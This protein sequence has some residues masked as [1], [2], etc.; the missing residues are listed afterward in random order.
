MERE[1]AVFPPQEAER[2]AELY[3]Y[4]ILDTGPD[5]AL[6][7]LV[8]LAAAICQA[9]IAVISLVDAERQWFKSKV[10]LTETQ[11][12]RIIA[13]CAHTILGD[14]LLVVPDARADP[15]FVENPLVV[16]EPHIRFYCG[17]PLTTPDGHHIG[18]LGVIDRVPR[19]LVLEQREAMRVLSHQVMDHLNLECRHKELVAAVGERLKAEQALLASQTKFQRLSD[20]TSSGIYIY[21]GEQFLYANPAASAISGFS[22]E[23]LKSLSLWD[24]VHP[25]FHAPLKARARAVEAGDQAPAR[26]EFPIIAKDGQIRWLDF[27][28]ASIEYDGQPARI[29]TAIDITTQKQAE[30]ALHLSEERFALAVAGTDAGIWD[31]DVISNTVYY[32]PRWKSMLGYGEQDLPDV[33]TTWETLLHPDDRARALAAVNDYLEGKT[34]CYEL[35]HRLRHKDGSYRWIL[36]RGAVLR[37]A[38]G[39]P[40]RMAGSHLD[41]TER[42]QAEVL[43]SVEREALERVSKGAPLSE[44]MEFLVRSI[45]SLSNGGICSILLV[46]PD[47]CTLRRGA[48]PTLPEA[49]SRAIDGA[50]IGPRN[51]S[52]GTAVYRKTTVVVADIATDPLWAP[53]TEAKELALRHGLRACTSVPIIG[54]TGEVLGTYAMYYRDAR[55]PTDFE[56]E[57]LRAS[58]HLLSITID[59]LRANE[60]LRTTQ[61]NLRQVLKATK[62]GTW[63]WNIITGEVRFNDD[64]LANLGYDRKDLLP[65]VSSWER[66]VHPDDVLPMRQRIQDHFDGKTTLY[67]SVNRLRRKDGTY[68]WNRDRGQV[69]ERDQQ[70]RPLR[71]VGTDTDIT[72]QAAMAEQAM[73]WEQVFAKARFGLAYGNID[74]NTLVAVNEAFASERGYTVS[75]LVGKPILSVYAPEA[76][77][78]MKGRMQ[79]IDR[80]GHLVYESVHQRKDGTTF[81][82]LME[83]T[84]IK[85]AQGKP[86]SRVA[87]AVDITDRHRAERVLREREERFRLVAEVTNDVLWD[88]DLITDDHW[89]SPNARERFGYDPAKEPSIEAWRSR[90]HPE[91]RARVLRH[92]HDS[93]TSGERVYFDEYRFLLADGTYGVFC[94]KGQIISDAEG[95]PVRMIGAMIDVTGAKRTYAELE[96]AYTR[97]QWLSRQVQKAE[98]KERRRLSRELHDDFGQLLSALRLRLARASEEMM[99]RPGTNGSALKRNL[100]MASKTVDQLFISLREL[101]HGLRPA[102][103]DELGLVAA[104]QSMAEEIRQ[105]AG[106]DCRLFVEPKKVASIIGQELEGT[107]FRIVQ[108]LVTNVVRHAKATSVDIT[109]CYAD[110]TITLAV[111]DNGRGGRVTEPKKGYGLRGIRERAELLG[112]QIEIRSVRQKGTTVTVTIPLEPLDGDGG[113]SGSGRP[114]RSRK[115]RQLPDEKQV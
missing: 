13:F 98:E 74:D 42:K 71:M 106:L 87:Y 91:D 83:V 16:G 92:L 11:T 76:R 50:P 94:D 12:A 45:E 23:E 28:A 66:L 6:D 59:S 9:P 99:K 73:R 24:L 60:A 22:V 107:L 81:P 104:L 90:L 7:D 48:V 109:L 54:A 51:G 39:K 30:R 29:G 35:E 34:A 65:H 20:C 32:S 8:H 78:E 114:T 61:A 40:L 80:L 93:V 15:R 64:W 49:Y 82:V 14:D 21:S 52:C 84:V 67:E 57:L 69:V 37:D 115:A 25:D 41:V 108:E 27:T 75:E 5:K 72:E 68:Q 44:T 62:S 36:A 79:E 85:N 38:T 56:M 95:K 18:T 4:E 88:W 17:A 58:T 89:W 1:H 70:G 112:G 100:M 102:V 26:F 103:L 86:I 43:K 46:G 96:Q 55:G 19:E 101:V 2:L 111:Q 105:G 110:G 97:L 53:W 47:G 63:N 113:P 31:W 10:G 3:R 77:E 33:F